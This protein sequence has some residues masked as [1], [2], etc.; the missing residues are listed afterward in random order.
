[1]PDGEEQTGRQELQAL[2]LLF[3]RPGGRRRTAQGRR[4]GR[5]VSL[6]SAH[7]PSALRRSGDSHDLDPASR[8]SQQCQAT[9]GK[10]SLPAVAGAAAAA[11]AGVADAQRLVLMC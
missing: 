9:H 6:P 10:L 11:A 1:M 7:R 2:S 8:S 4:E 5:P 3:R